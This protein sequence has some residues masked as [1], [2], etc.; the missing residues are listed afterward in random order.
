[1]ALSPY[2]IRAR[3]RRAAF[4]L[5]T[6]AA[7]LGMAPAEAATSTSL[8]AATARCTADTGP[9]QRQLEGFLRLRVDGVQSDADCEAIRRFQQRQ[10]VRPADGTANLWTYRMMLVVQ[11]GRNPNRAGHCPV[12]PRRVTCVDMDRQLLWVQTGRRVDFGPVPVRTG[13]D[14]QETRH[15]WHTVYWRHRDHYSNLFH[16]APMPYAQFF[17]RGQA[18]HGSPHDLY[19]GGGSAGCINLRVPD[20]ERL[21]QLLKV[22]DL[23]YVWGAKPGT[24]G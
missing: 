5:L 7:L 4:V 9:Y 1:M 16:H 23:V 2:S 24:L 21:W 15:G 17:D 12:R 19:N 20:A 8:P 14:G 3:V 11:A 6:G 18:L 22:G 10:G 13:R